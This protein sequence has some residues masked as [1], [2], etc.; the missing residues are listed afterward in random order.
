MYASFR[1]AVKPPRT[2]PYLL[3]LF[4][5]TSALIPLV[6]VTIAALG[7]AN[8]GVVGVVLDLLFAISPSVLLY[9]AGTFPLEVELP[10]QDVA[11]AHDVRYIVSCN[12]F[13][14]NGTCLLGRFPPTTS[15]CQRTRSHCGPGSHFR[16]SS[17]F[18]AW[19]RRGRSTSQTCGACP[20]T[21]RTRTYS[22]NILRMPNSELRLFVKMSDCHH[23]MGAGFP[24]IHSS[25][26]SSSPIPSI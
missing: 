5:L 22:R 10:G 26:S 4:Y 3:V 13:D 9:V 16:L 20:R 11:T 18:L 7:W 12:S 25:A 14:F 21:S 15:R 19:P 8:P 23:Q 1:V 2:P 17:R 24:H 6:E